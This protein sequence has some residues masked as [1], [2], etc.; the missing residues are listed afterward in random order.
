MVRVKG[1]LHNT[2]VSWD[3]ICHRNK[4]CCGILRKMND[5]DPLDAQILLALDDDPDATTLGLAR[6]L[7]VARNTVHARLRR[8]TR[9]TLRPFSHRVD[10]AA[11]GYRLVA[12]VSLSISQ[13]TGH[14]TVPGLSRLPE[15]IEIHSI[16]GPA[17]FLVKV[18]ALDT[19]DLYRVTNAILA[20]DG[21]VRT[22]TAISLMEAMP[23]RIRPLLES[24]AG[25]D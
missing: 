6:T 15:V 13:H 17:D 11:L 25:T 8:L 23:T 19:E 5:V 3:A 12:F 14:L 7:G 1:S 16:S 9:T 10:P 4:P 22:D 24:V 2:A 18:V 20:V 21:V